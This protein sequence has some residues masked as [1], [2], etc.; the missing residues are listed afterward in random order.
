MKI[1]YESRLAELL[2]EGSIAFTFRETVYVKG[3]RITLSQLLHESEHVRQFRAYGTIGF[4]LRHFWYRAT[5]GYQANPLEVQARAFAQRR[6]IECSLLE[7][8]SY[9]ESF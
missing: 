7:N 9:L 8:A 3:A 5:L 6:M 4:L 1:V 2:P